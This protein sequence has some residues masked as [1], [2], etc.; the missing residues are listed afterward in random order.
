MDGTRQLE[1]ELD[2]QMLEQAKGN[3]A[4]TASVD[5]T[6]LSLTLTI[7]IYIEASVGQR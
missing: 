4:E 7:H 3:S 1:V 2:G 6:R 5:E